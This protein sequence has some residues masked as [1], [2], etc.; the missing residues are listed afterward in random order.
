MKRLK[1]KIAYQDNQDKPTSSTPSPT[2]DSTTSTSSS[3]GN[4]TP[5]TPLHTTR[6][7]D[8][9]VY[10]VDILAVLAIGVC[11]FF[12]Y[13]ASQAKNKKPSMKN[14]IN[15]QNDAPCFRK[16]VIINE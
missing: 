13:N 16:I 15:Y 5:S 14:N 11:V 6:S 2:G 7:N 3:I 9:Y 4:S 12:A 8:T 10:G 1:E